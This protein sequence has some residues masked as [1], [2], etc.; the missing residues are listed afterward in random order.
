MMDF[1]VARF[2]GVA[3]SPTADSLSEGLAAD[4][5]D[6]S[7]GDE[8]PDGGRPLVPG[9]G[10][11]RVNGISAYESDMYAAGD[12]IVL[13]ALPATDFPWL[14]GASKVILVAVDQQSSGEIVGI[15]QPNPGALARAIRG[16]V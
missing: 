10:R 12:G 6:W 3:G 16:V 9:L 7:L 2:G 8:G 13:Y 4:G 14:T 11:T 15:W 5:S 1:A